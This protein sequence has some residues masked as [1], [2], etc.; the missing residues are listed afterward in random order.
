MSSQIARSSIVSDYC[1][2][3]LN[4]L[5]AAGPSPT[6]H[7]R[8]QGRAHPY[9]TEPPF[10]HHAPVV[11]IIR[12][13]FYFRKPSSPHGNLLRRRICRGTLSATWAASLAGMGH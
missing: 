13:G 9:T 2:N 4:H 11:R 1:S 12:C 7:T 8:T 3:R 6:T 10:V 5:L